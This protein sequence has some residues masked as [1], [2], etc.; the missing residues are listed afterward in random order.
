MHGMASSTVSP[1]FCMIPHALHGPMSTVWSSEICMVLWTLHS[2][3]EMH[4]VWDPENCIVP[5]TLHNLR[6]SMYCMIPRV[7]QEAS[8][9]TFRFNLITKTHTKWKFWWR[10][11]IFWWKKWNIPTNEPACPSTVSMYHAHVLVEFYSSSLWICSWMISG[12]F[13]L[14][15]SDVTIWKRRGGCDKINNIKSFWVGNLK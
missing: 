8:L 15:W 7:P 11:E 1:E 9:N 3:W 10:N 13:L 2:P 6:F 4:N 5:W 14:C 12:Y